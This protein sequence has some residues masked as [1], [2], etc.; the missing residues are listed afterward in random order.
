MSTLSAEQQHR[1][2]L[3]SDTKVNPKIAASLGLKIAQPV[4]AKPREEEVPL[5]LTSAVG[6]NAPGGAE[7]IAPANQ[8]DLIADLLDKPIAT[9]TSSKDKSASSAAPCFDP[10]ATA[11]ESSHPSVADAAA[12]GEQADSVEENPA[13]DAFAPALPENGTATRT[14][15]PEDM[16]SSLSSPPSTAAK[17]SEFVA[18]LGAGGYGAKPGVAGKPL[19]STASKPDPFADLFK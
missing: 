1:R 3:L 13:W 12:P 17:G 14:A 9:T 2:K 11:L 5:G 7:P 15:L 19:E 10:F 18:M 6:T 4:P 16:F 8:V